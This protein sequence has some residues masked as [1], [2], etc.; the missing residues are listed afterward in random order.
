MLRIFGRDFSCC[1]RASRRN[2]LSAGTLALGGLT[3]TDLLR[4]Q[5]S[6]GE[7][8]AGQPGKRRSASVI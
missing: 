6:A 8:A 2:F 7:T 3:L 1:D 4:L 5:A